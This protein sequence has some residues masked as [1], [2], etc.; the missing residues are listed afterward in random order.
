[1]IELTANAEKKRLAARK[2]QNSEEWA[3]FS[4]DSLVEAV[5]KARELGW[6]D[7]K[8]QV[9]F[10]SYSEDVVHYYIEPYEKGCECKGILRYK[11]FF[12]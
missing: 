5:H 8:V 1:M 12:D 9:R 4:T 2:A 11:D 3:L 7:K 6:K 10:E